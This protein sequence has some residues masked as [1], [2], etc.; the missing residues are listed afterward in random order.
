MIQF[1]I[2]GPLEVYVDGEAAALG[3][4]RQRAVLGRLLLDPRRVVSADRIIDDVWEGHPPD[5]AR[6]T[7]HKYVFE[8][9]KV[10]PSPLLRTAPAG[11]VLDVDDEAIDARRFERLVAERRFAAALALWR[12][13]PLADL[14]DLGFLAPGGDRPRADDARRSRPPRRRPAVGGADLSRRARRPPGDRR[15]PL[16]G[17]DP[18]EPGDRRGASR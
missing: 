8:L 13:D 6:K 16:H 12:G 14:P 18:Q 11:Y 1:G 3:G 2:L 9:R 4:P 5:T 15:P 17:V 7:L 10:L